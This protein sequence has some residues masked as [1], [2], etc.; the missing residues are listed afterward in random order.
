MRTNI[1][2]DDELVRRG[3]ELTG[4]R[5]K[6]ELVQLALTELVRNRTRKSL[7]DLA[8]RLRFADRFDPHEIRGKADDPR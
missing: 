4:I 8:G 1:V 2:L 3:Q 7:L 6:R 5:T